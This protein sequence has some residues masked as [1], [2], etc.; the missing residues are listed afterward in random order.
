MGPKT[1][2]LV[3]NVNSGKISNSS[4]K[5]PNFRQKLKF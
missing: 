4:Q 2:R 1:E 3:R 5:I